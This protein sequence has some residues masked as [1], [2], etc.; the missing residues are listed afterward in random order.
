MRIAIA[1]PEQ[2][3]S[4]QGAKRDH[5]EQGQDPE[6]NSPCRASLTWKILMR[7]LYASIAPQIIHALL[8]VVPGGRRLFSTEIDPS[9]VREGIE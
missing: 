7:L 6:Q 4:Y 1:A 3:V 5:R 8:D 9:N 2:L